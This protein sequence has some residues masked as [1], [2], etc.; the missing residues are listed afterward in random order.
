MGKTFRSRPEEGSFGFQQHRTPRA[1]LAK[2]RRVVSRIRKERA[3]NP[4]LLLP[5]VVIVPLETQLMYE[6][7]YVPEKTAAEE[8][9]LQEQVRNQRL[10]LLQQ[11][12]EHALYGS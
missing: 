6:D 1:E 10:E 5:P 4:A 9:P 11:L 7:G 8:V 12:G 2:I 3:P